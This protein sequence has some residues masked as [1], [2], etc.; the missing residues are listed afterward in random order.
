[1]I[2]NEMFVN[3]RLTKLRSALSL[4]HFAIVNCGGRERGRERDVS[5]V[6]SLRAHEGESNSA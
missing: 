2:C 4:D 6:K 3:V 5:C 1:M